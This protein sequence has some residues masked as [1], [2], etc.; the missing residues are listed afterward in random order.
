M[1]LFDLLLDK[2]KDGKTRYQRAIISSATKYQID[3]AASD[4]GIDTVLCTQLVVENGEFT[5]AVV[6][7]TCWGQ[8]KVTA[9]ETLAQKTPEARCRATPISQRQFCTPMFRS[10]I[11]GW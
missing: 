10:K 4:L 8:G 3:R 7:P 9:A 11:T 1:S 6:K 5:G 2:G